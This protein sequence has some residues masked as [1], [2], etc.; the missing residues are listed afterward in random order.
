[1]CRFLKADNTQCK[2]SPKKDLCHRHINS[3]TSTVEEP[4]EQKKE[5]VELIQDEEKHV[6]EN[7][8]SP[9]SP[10]TSSPVTSEPKSAILDSVKSESDK[11]N[12]N[13]LF[14]Q[15]AAFLKDNAVGKWHE[16]FTIK[17]K[18]SEEYVH[19]PLP[20]MSLLRVEHEEGAHA[21]VKGCR[22]FY[23]IYNSDDAT[24][25][26]EYVGMALY[27]ECHEVFIT[28]RTR[29]FFDIDL[30]LDVMEKI[31]IA[32]AMGYPLGEG[33]DEV[34]VM[35]I[36]SKKLAVVYR[37]AIAISL[38]EKD[39]LDDSNGFDWMATTRNRA[40]S[41]DGFK[42]SIHLITNMMLSHA[43]C[44]AIAT[45][46][47]NNVISEN[48]EVL[49][50]PE[51][52]IDLVAGA[53]DPA[54]YRKHGSL[55]LPFGKK[56]GNISW[57]ARS[58]GTAGQR[59]FLS[60][61]D[62][63]TIEDVDMS[64]YNVQTTSCYTGL[65]N[66][67]F[68]KQALSHVDAIPD[69]SS[70]VFDIGASH[71]KGSVMFL[72]RYQPSNCSF[73]NRIHDNDNTLKLY[74]NSDIGFATW[75]CIRSE[76]KS[77]RFFT[78]EQPAASLD[79]EDIERFANTRAKPVEIKVK[80][81]AIKPKRVKQSIIDMDDPFD[82]DDM[83]NL[84]ETDSVDQELIDIDL[85]LIRSDPQ[86]YS[87]ALYELCILIN[88][89][90]FRDSKNIWN[91]SRSFYQMP[92]S[93]P[94]VMRNTYA[95]VLEY[96]G[97]QWF[98]V[99]AAMAQYLSD[100]PSKKFAVMSLS[101]LKAI[102]GGSDA[103]RYS[104]WKGKYDPD[105]IKV[106]N[107]SNDSIGAG[108]ESKD[109]VE[110]R[111]GKRWV[112]EASKVC[113]KTSISYD[114]LI[115]GMI[116]NIEVN[117]DYCMMDWRDEFI[118]PMNH[119]VQDAEVPLGDFIALAGNWVYRCA[120]E[121]AKFAAQIIDSTIVLFANGDVFVRQKLDE[122][123]D[124]GAKKTPSTLMKLI[125]FRFFTIDKN[126][127]KV[128]R[129]QT[130]DKLMLAY[131]PM[132]HR[133][134]RYVSR[135]DIDASD[136]NT[137]G[138]CAPYR[139]RMLTDDQYDPTM[140]DRFLEFVL[141]VICD[142]DHEKYRF[143]LDYCEHSIRYKNAK[144]G[145]AMIFYTIEKGCGKGTIMKV[146]DWVF[147]GWNTATESGT[148]SRTVGERNSHILGKKLVMIDELEK[149]NDKASAGLVE[150]WKN[151]I[152]EDKIATT[153]LY[154]S[155]IKI[156]NFTNHMITTN[157]LAV[158]HIPSMKDVSTDDDIKA[159]IRRFCVFKLNTKYKQDI[160]FFRDFQSYWKTQSFADH[161]YTYFMNRCELD[162]PA[163][164]HT[165]ISDELRG[166]VGSQ[167]PAHIEFWDDLR[168]NTAGFDS[169]C[170]IGHIEYAPRIAKYKIAVP[171]AYVKY[172]TF[173]EAAGHKH[174]L[175]RSSFVSMSKELSFIHECK[176]T[177][178][179]ETFYF[180]Y[181]PPVEEESDSD[182]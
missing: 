45:H 19:E 169:L 92:M 153:P 96:H 50:I 36:V 83:P 10:N 73:C 104:S 33:C 15:C 148:V 59:Y 130:L 85:E 112:T 163:P 108:L 147:G 142:N 175:K 7:I 167:K 132:F 172:V 91:L 21:K 150:K 136:K 80:P 5:P 114:K 61:V 109:D 178:G 3:A 14:N 123:E 149:A 177:K 56:A 39:A 157:N 101:K 122:C 1:M 151:Q 34:A 25:F 2:L 28:P 134:N 49:N 58:Y 81:V 64:N 37:D 176:T 145:V 103:K 24:K 48:A 106:E 17:K 78:I 20:N 159:I 70:D 119:I 168:D 120:E 51:S 23:W 95:L 141:T 87:Q 86:A 4:V 107:A 115:A 110:Y 89:T 127:D 43:S 46:I 166:I 125:N 66:D 105:Q 94:I 52:I 11:I 164:L 54:Q 29:M 38:E 99:K 42:I 128:I 9:M 100:G 41:D 68:V 27:S 18:D 32:E 63:F 171:R 67:D 30:K 90:W 138:M 173:C 126:G 62:M 82:G 65:A 13:P 170:N 143:F 180:D 144:T 16:S 31:D 22:R 117:G 76:L 74:F 113:E 97:G 162:S 124:D 6:S 57:I 160:G 84:D 93:D 161:F 40:I 111:L 135:W 72:K 118:Q 53:I 156:D 12:C 179:V 102:A 88:P 26:N 152:T 165:V 44:A 98:N 174:P 75:K 133:Y 154:S 77:R 79:A 121:A 155:T 55:G 139:G 181:V 182:D 8:V 137:F 60:K 131:S 158:L 116:K 35:D 140:L 129:S 146:F 69:Y 71:M 47:Q